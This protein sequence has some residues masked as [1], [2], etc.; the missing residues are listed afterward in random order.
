MRKL[1]L[2]LIFLSMM[3]C[4]AD[5]IVP[6]AGIV[7]DSQQEQCTIIPG[8]GIYIEQDAAAAGGATPFI[9]INTWG[10]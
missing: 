7:S 5:Y 9:I 2:L 8:A 10:M 4:G 1:I 3:L 6:G